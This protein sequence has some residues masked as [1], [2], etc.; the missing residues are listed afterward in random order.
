MKK[1]FAIA[2]V[3]VMMLSL[4]ACGNDSKSDKVKAYVEDNKAVLLSGMEQSFASSS[5][6]TCTSSIRV[7]GCGIV[8]DININELDG[9][10]DAEKKL[11]QEIYD[12]LDAQ[13]DMAFDQMQ[14]ELPELEFFTVNVNEG[15]G[16]NIAVVKMD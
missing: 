7:D 1:I 8:I 9:L 14:Q 16:D 3:L 10:G 4:V 11:M 6:M 2:L 15:D 5:G 13:F 12:S